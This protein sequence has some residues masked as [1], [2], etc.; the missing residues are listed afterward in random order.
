MSGSWRRRVKRLRAFS[1]VNGSD[2]FIGV[3]PEKSGEIA[4]VE[5]DASKSSFIHTPQKE[6]TCVIITPNLHRLINIFAANFSN[7]TDNC[8]LNFP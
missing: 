3:A 4:N 2:D 6:S 5:V 1:S 8:H 7:F